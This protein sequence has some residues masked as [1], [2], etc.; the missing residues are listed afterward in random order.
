MKPESRRYSDCLSLFLRYNG[1]Q[2]VRIEGEMREELDHGKFSRRILYS[3]F[4]R[5]TYKPGW[6][7]R[8]GWRRLLRWNAD[9]LVRRDA[10]AS[11][12]E[13][14]RRQAAVQNSKFP[15]RNSKSGTQN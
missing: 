12:A 7:E 11:T 1:T 3:R 5:G 9:T 2:H 10:S 4:E 8:H 6:I 13:T 14:P 15:I